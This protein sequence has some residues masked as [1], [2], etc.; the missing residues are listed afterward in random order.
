MAFLA[1]KVAVPRA[2]DLDAVRSR[3]CVRNAQGDNQVAT[4]HAEPATV[5]PVGSLLRDPSFLC[6]WT[7]GGLTGIVRWL[8]L[9]VLGLYTY[10]ITG[11]PLLVSVVP[12]LW[13]LPLALC[14]PLMGVI[15]DRFNRKALI[16]ISVT[17]VAAMCVG[18]AVLARV[19]G[20]TFADVAVVSLLSGLFWST[21]M[22]VR[23]RLLGDLSGDA[24]S[25]AMGLDSATGNATRM[26]GPLIGGIMLE[27]FSISGVFVLSAVIYASCLVLIAMVR[28]PERHRVTMGSR[29]FL[30]FLGGIQYVLGN[31]TLRRIF[32]I[33]IV[34]N[35]F[36]FPFTSMIPIIGTDRLGLTPLL[37]G[38][39][40]ST[41]G[42]GAFIG[43]IVLAFFA[44]RE[45]F[46]TIYACSTTLYVVMVGYIGILSLVA[47]GPSHSA[48][49][50]SG[51]L[52]I[53]GMAGA[54]FAAMQ[55][56]LTY[57]A[58]PAQYR[59]RVL[60]VLTL[61]IGSAPIGFFNIGWMAET[62]GVP[63]ALMIASVEGIT[64]LL[65][66]WLY[67]NQSKL[68]FAQ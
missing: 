61:C 64:V 8:Q 3:T 21:D 16:A 54:G 63:M 40:S 6:V 65:L 53:T 66:L 38:M 7:I 62:F 56:T 68:V 37:V 44:R 27:L 13:M 39:L 23:R 4:S 45:H 31:S 51:A 19:D 49:V 24:L 34:F 9:L 29:F 28:V 33:T 25:A 42:L 58:A 32:A 60:G 43:A 5:S 46:F 14:G 57:L 36:G 50:T 10:E 55:G 18:T 11:S 15:A 47:G 67:G 41:E 2:A 48:V 22:P 12:M 17:L 26:A 20:L 59:S 35:V 1:A 52:L 30:E